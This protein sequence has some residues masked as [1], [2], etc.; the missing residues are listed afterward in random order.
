MG[1]PKGSKNKEQT[2]RQLITQWRKDNP[3]KSVKE[4]LDALN[5]L[6]AA[7]DP[8]LTISRATAYRYW[9]NGEAEQ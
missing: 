7:I 9:K 5:E 4:S 1:R 3:Y 8:K 6:A 2:R